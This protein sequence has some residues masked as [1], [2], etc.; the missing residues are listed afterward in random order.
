MNIEREC[1]EC[2][3]SEWKRI[4]RKTY[5]DRRERDRDKTEQIVFDCAECGAQ[6]KRFEDGFGGEITFSGALR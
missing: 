3:A 4:V 5:P 6:G 2:G 1:S